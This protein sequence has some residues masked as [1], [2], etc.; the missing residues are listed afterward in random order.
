MKN[1][2]WS[3]LGVM[4]A[5]TLLSACDPYSSQ[6][7]AAPVVVM[8]TT[9]D[10]T[11]GSNTA[12][13]ESG[14][15]W[16]VT[17]VPSSCA[18]GVVTSDEPVLFVT[19]NQL[20]DGASI[21]AG[22]TDC[23]PAGAWLAATPA[24][25]AGT[26]WYSCFQPG[27]PSPDLGSAVTLFQAA[28]GG[29]SGWDVAAYPLANND[30]VTAYTF[31]GNVRDWQGQSMAVHV[32]VNVAPN[33]GP[34]G[35]PTFANI[36]ATS[37]DVSWAASTCQAAGTTYQLERAPDASGA[38]GTWAVIAGPAVGLSTFSDAHT[39]GLY[40]YRVRTRTTT[41]YFGTNS[42]Q[43]STA[44]AVAAAPTF[45]GVTATSVTVNWTATTYATSYDVQRAPDAFGVP[46]TFAT[47]A[48]G[49]T[50]TTYTDTTVAGATKYW[51]RVV[52]INVTGSTRGRSASVTT[53]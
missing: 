42:K 46:G 32:N 20:L 29:V 28:S 41:G 45:T 4:A 10:P 48:P 52:A 18:A 39:A 6:N 33:P 49:Q 22:V 47:I 3:I 8:V 43:L 9:S 40:W 31:N 13:T 30:A 27:S 2:K 14:G 53:P 51:Y 19:S 7:K 5:A 12:G 35:D 11:T 23:T 15:V 24:A 38:P 44:P 1:I 26:A 17:D 37:V 21:Q 34:A 36:T 16:T 25:P 50:G